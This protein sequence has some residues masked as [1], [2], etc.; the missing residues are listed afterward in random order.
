MNISYA[1][2][3]AAPELSLNGD[4]ISLFLGE[5]CRKLNILTHLVKPYLI[6]AINLNIIKIIFLLY[7]PRM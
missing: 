7:S 5:S 3:S 1:C 4:E 6:C 2:I